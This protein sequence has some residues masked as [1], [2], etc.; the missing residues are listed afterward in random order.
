MMLPE[1]EP[2]AAPKTATAWNALKAQLL[3]MAAKVLSEASMAAK[4]S[5][6]SFDA[7][8]TPVAAR[9]MKDKLRVSDVLVVV[10]TP[11]AVAST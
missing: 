6:A 7:E 10:V 9:A 4:V 2:D 11:R 1:L 5:E 3:P 8:A